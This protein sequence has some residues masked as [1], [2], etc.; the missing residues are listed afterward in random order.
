ML[1][2]EDRDGVLGSGESHHLGVCS[3]ASLSLLLP[4]RPP[5]VN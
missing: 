3:A 1:E 5:S 4:Q 2:E